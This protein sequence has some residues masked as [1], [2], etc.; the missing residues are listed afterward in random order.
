MFNFCG[1][2]LLRPVHCRAETYRL[3]H[4]FRW[5]R[6]SSILSCVGVYPLQDW[7][8]DYA[9]AL[10]GDTFVLWLLRTRIQ[11]SRRSCSNCLG[12]Q[13]SSSSV[14]CAHHPS[15]Q[16]N[17]EPGWNPALQSS[18]HQLP[19]R[20]FCFKSETYLLTSLTVWL[21]V[22]IREGRKSSWISKAVINVDDTVDHQHQLGE[23]HRQNNVHNSASSP[24]FRSKPP[25]REH[26][27]AS[28][29]RHGPH[30]RW[31]LDVDGFMQAK[32]GNYWRDATWAVEQF[33]ERWKCHPKASVPAGYSSSATITTVLLFLS[34]WH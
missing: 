32:Y 28:L 33:D 22:D 14:V 13:S 24:T 18:L 5:G 30:T 1:S 21:T 26:A 3:G 12:W 19:L 31:R 16:D 27:S 7:I 20:T 25:W 15:V 9:T 6:Y 29:R 11:L 4:F 8:I 2:R 34:K 17:S 23:Y 10:L